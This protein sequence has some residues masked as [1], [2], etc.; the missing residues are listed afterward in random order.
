M[1]NINTDPEFNL[2]YALAINDTG[3]RIAASCY[4]RTTSKGVVY[5]FRRI[6]TT[7]AKESTITFPITG[8]Q[9]NTGSGFGNALSLD[10][11]GTRLLI[12][13][14]LENSVN[15][16]G[17]DGTA[18]V[19]AFNGMDWVQ[20]ARIVPGTLSLDARFGFS[21]ALSPDG[22]LALIGAPNHNNLQGV[23]F[24][25]VR[26]GTLWTLLQVLSNPQL[27]SVAQ[28]G[29]Q[30]AMSAD[31]SFLAVSAPI[32]SSAGTQTGTITVFKLVD[33]IYT[34]SHT[35]YPPAAT[36]DARLGMKMVMNA[37]GTHIAASYRA[38]ATER[39]YVQLY[40]LSGPDALTA[41]L[42]TGSDTLPGGL[43]GRAIALSSAA[44]VM[45]V[46]AYYNDNQ[47]QMVGGVYLFG[48]L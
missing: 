26:T 24:L 48:A 9:A 44:D 28:F 15:G 17:D 16:R 18:Y 46:G 2:G 21:V 4:N 13:S 6:G 40:R 47:A 33:G 3:D 31:K 37:Q 36:P 42:L 34:R 1:A 22:T 12:G 23:A 7:W 25:Y 35:L 45:G 20:E 11:A 10:S 14:N 30:V 5:I 32:D 8:A 27:T 43:F 41:D 39:G 38:N 29:F 19:Y